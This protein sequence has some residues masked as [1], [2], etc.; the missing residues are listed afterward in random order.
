ML[1]GHTDIYPFF[2]F[3]SQPGASYTRYLLMIGQLYCHGTIEGHCAIKFVIRLKVLK[4]NH[5]KKLSL[6][7]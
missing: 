6:R 7:K 2:C 1:P 5:Y 4:I 3:L